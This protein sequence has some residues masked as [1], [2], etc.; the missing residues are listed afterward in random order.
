MVYGQFVIFQ[1]FTKSENDRT[2]IK[3]YSVQDYS[4][5][6]NVVPCLSEN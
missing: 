5:F 2:L 6:K 4:E 3:T 1:P